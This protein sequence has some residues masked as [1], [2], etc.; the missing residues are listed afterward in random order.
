M[1]RN[2]RNVAPKSASAVVK[3][4]PAQY[5]AGSVGDV[6]ERLVAVF[7][8]I[9]SSKI[10]DQTTSLFEQDAIAVIRGADSL[11][12][13]LR[14]FLEEKFTNIE[15]LYPVHHLGKEA[16]HE[17]IKDLAKL[18]AVD[19]AE[20]MSIYY[21]F[22][23]LLFQ[24]AKSIAG[25]RKGD[26]HFALLTG[27]R[28]RA[29]QAIADFLKGC[30]LFEGINIFL[31]DTQMTEQY[32]PEQ[33]GFKTHKDNFRKGKEADIQRLLSKTFVSPASAISMSEGAAAGDEVASGRFM[34]EQISSGLNNL[35]RLIKKLSGNHLAIR[36]HPEGES[37]LGSEFS[38][39]LISISEMQLD[40]DS[41][42]LHVMSWMMKDPSANWI[43]APTEAEMTQALQVVSEKIIHLV[44]KSKLKPAEEGKIVFTGQQAR[45]LALISEK[46]KQIESRVS[47]QMPA[48]KPVKVKAQDVS[49]LLMPEVPP[50]PLSSAPALLPNSAE[51]SS[52]SLSA[53]LADSSFASSSDSSPDVS[54]SPSPVSSLVAS[55]SPSPVS[56]LVVAEEKPK[57]VAQEKP[58]AAVQDPLLQSVKE[59]EEVAKSLDKGVSIIKK[60]TI[61][62]G[63]QTKG[64]PILAP[65][66]PSKVRARL[67]EALIAKKQFF[68]VRDEGIKSEL[69][70]RYEALKQS[71]KG[72]DGLEK[73]LSGVQKVITKAQAIEKKDFISWMPFKEAARKAEG[74]AITHEAKIA[75]DAA[76]Q[77]EAQQKA[78]DEKKWKAKQ[79]LEKKV[80]EEE[81]KIIQQQKA[82]QEAQA[83]AQNAKE[84]LM[85]LEAAA[86]IKAD[87]EKSAASISSQADQRIKSLNE[88]ANCC[89]NFLRYFSQ[90]LINYEFINASNRTSEND[91]IVKDIL[92]YLV[93]DVS[94]KDSQSNLYSAEKC[95]SIFQSFAKSLNYFS[96]QV[97]YFY[98]QEANWHVD[99]ICSFQAALG[100]YQ[101]IFTSDQYLLLPSIDFKIL[102]SIQHSML[103]GNISILSERLIENGMTIIQAR[104]A[105]LE[106]AKKFKSFLSVRGLDNID[107]N[108]VLM[109]FMKESES[110]DLIEQKLFETKF[111]YNAFRLQKYM[112]TEAG[113]MMFSGLKQ[114]LEMQEFLQSKC[115]MLPS[116]KINPEPVLHGGDLLAL[117]LQFSSGAKDQ[118]A[119]FVRDGKMESLLEITARHNFALIAE[120]SSAPYIAAV[121]EDLK[122]KMTCYDYEKA[123][124][125]TPD[126][127]RICNSLF[128]L[129]KSFAN[130]AF[131]QFGLAASEFLLQD[132]I[133]KRFTIS[134]EA[135]FI[136][137]LLKAA[138][139][140]KGSIPEK[141]YRQTIA[142]L[143]LA[144]NELSFNTRRFADLSLAAQATSYDSPQVQQE[145]ASV[146][147]GFESAMDL[148]C[149]TFARLAIARENH[150]SLTVA[151]SSA[152]AF[153]DDVPAAQVSHASV[154]IGSSA[155]FDKDGQILSEGELPQ[156][157]YD[158]IDDLISDEED[159]SASPSSAAQPTSAKVGSINVRYNPN[160]KT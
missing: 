64:A 129:R 48:A 115:P 68:G 54:V 143:H 88:T 95:R 99:L 75:A 104:N 74:I 25:F 14:K 63:K 140:S 27:N 71:V 39:L 8:K 55:V 84:V 157:L 36:N 97:K 133:V 146:L 45:S 149:A 153:V 121:E 23:G 106:S 76:K 139:E 60:F 80:K 69:L 40:A 131:S 46:V 101:E 151:S 35:S 110:R 19:E 12:P 5:D 137:H 96:S 6:M 30:E 67:S 102:A 124:A 58:K 105:F 9:L 107:V 1:R 90:F 134:Q 111:F 47:F 73:I 2:R 51:V 38:N 136:P 112:Q 43:E 83:K 32:V 118:V 135:I 3:D 92:Q 132:G 155:I 117:L 120:Y 78:D 123:K 89:V 28:L 61:D 26:A 114:D 125:F 126:L 24:D 98:M 13:N 53:S 34:E 52:R 109:E 41:K 82:Q 142:T 156:E 50:L 21:P 17:N 144:I 100:N 152:A 11:D 86:A 79:D 128:E 85:A 93:V 158:A 72:R 20:A 119:Q 147:N 77:A 138:L 141:E 91:R 150:P 18:L 108:D 7:Q 66:D 94:D 70:S 113:E 148:F 22:F 4:R 15:L 103:Q 33:S 65:I 10:V 62:F 56:S 59:L 49:P 81:R 29:V 31:F 127:N 57:P 116:H 154:V 130:G 160:Q 87:A 145:F 42:D 44:E 159:G 122:Q 37:K 16:G